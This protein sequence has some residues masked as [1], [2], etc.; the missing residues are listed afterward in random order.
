MGIGSTRTNS[1]INPPTPRSNFQQLS[2]DL[3]RCNTDGAW[4]V[5]SGAAGQGWIFSDATTPEIDR[6]SLYKKHV[7]SPLLVE[8]LAIREAL[9]HVISLNINHIWV[10]SDSQVLIGAIYRNRRSTELYGAL[11]DIAGL[12]S[13]FTSCSFSFISRSCNGPADSLAKNCLNLCLS[14]DGHV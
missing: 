13:S 8:A 6:G 7:S 3:I 10:R 11:S 1:P 4:K 5:E 9:M 14:L 12:S 2:P